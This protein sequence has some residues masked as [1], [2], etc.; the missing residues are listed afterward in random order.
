M[1]R[2]EGSFMFLK[3][4]SQDNAS[5]VLQAIEGTEGTVSAAVFEGKCSSK[6]VR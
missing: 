3:D 1:A 6:I 5:A 4:S 2:P